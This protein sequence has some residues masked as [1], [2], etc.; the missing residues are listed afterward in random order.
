MTLVERCDLSCSFSM[1]ELNKLA[2]K[3]TDQSNAAGTLTRENFRRLLAEAAPGLVTS[4]LLPHIFAVVDANVSLAI[5]CLQVIWSNLVRHILL[6]QQQ[7]DKIDFREFVRGLA[8]IVQGNFEQKL[9][10]MFQVCIY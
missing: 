3:F 10:L 6:V 8:L 7:D 5:L 1:V 4:D 2:Q 9:E